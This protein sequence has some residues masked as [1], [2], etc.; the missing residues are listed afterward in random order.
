M[1]L[2]DAGYEVEEAAD[3]NIGL[4]INRENPADLIITDLIMPEKEGI[5][6]ILELKKD[7][8]DT[9]IIA[10]SGDSILDPDSYLS[11]A[12][13]IGAKRS[14]SKPIDMKELLAAVEELLK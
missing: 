7:F 12:E 4:Q 10:I 6:T 8:S 1:A 14:F 11:V 9:K 3:G 2:E 5:E 13:Q